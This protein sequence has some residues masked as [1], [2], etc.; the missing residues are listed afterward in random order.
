M[1]TTIAEIP[2]DTLRRILAYTQACADLTAGR[3]DFRIPYLVAEDWATRGSSQLSTND[4]ARRFGST[5]RTICKALSRL[6]EAGAIRRVG[7]DHE[8]GQSIYEPC[9]ERGDEWLTSHGGA[10]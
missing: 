9:L 7:H 2:E 3:H 5:R 4:L 10:E 6:V 8:T 1:K